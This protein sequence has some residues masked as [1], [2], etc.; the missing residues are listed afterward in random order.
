SPDDPPRSWRETHPG[1]TERSWVDRAVGVAGLPPDESRARE[2]EPSIGGHVGE[3]RRPVAMGGCRSSRGGQP[4]PK[5][6]TRAGKRTF[7]RRAIY[8]WPLDATKNGGDTTGDSIMSKRPRGQRR[9]LF[10]N[11]DSSIRKLFRL[12]L[13]IGRKTSTQ[14]TRR[15]LDA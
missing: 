4:Q 13:D 7:A 8:V 12:I 1:T 11:E 10:I 15:I 14:R 2:Q 9:V 5:C 6:R 3:F